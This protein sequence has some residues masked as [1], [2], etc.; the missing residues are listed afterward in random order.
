MMRFAQIIVAVFFLAAV[1]LVV[2]WGA[3]QQRDYVESDEGTDD[4][5]LLSRRHDRERRLSIFKKMGHDI[6]HTVDKGTKDITKGVDD[7]KKGEKA[8]VKGAKQTE[9]GLIKAGDDVSHMTKEAMDAIDHVFSSKSLEKMGQKIS[10]AASHFEQGLEHVAEE[11]AQDV[12]KLGPLIVSAAEATEEVMKAFSQLIDLGACFDFKKIMCKTLL[13]MC[14]CDAG[15]EVSVSLDKPPKIE[16]T[17]VPKYLAKSLNWQSNGQWPGQLEAGEP[18]SDEDDDE[19][20]GE[21]ESD[22]DLKSKM[23][24]VKQD[25]GASLKT[26]VDANIEFIP[27]TVFEL[28]TDGKLTASI[29]GKFSAYLNARAEADA[30]FSYTLVERVPEEPLEYTACADVFCI[31]FLLQAN[32]TLDLETSAQGT[33]QV[34]A[35][36]EYDIEAD[37]SIDVTTG[38]MHA[39][40]KSS[41]FTH[42]EQMTMDGSFDGSLSLSLMPVLTIMPLPGAPISVKPFL[43]GNLSTHVEASATASSAGFLQATSSTTEASFCAAADISI[44]G[45]V[46]IDGLGMPQPLEISSTEIKSMITKAIADVP[47]VLIGAIND[48]LDSCAKLGKAVDKAISKP[49]E[50]AA[51][52]A[53]KGLD[54]VIPDFKVSLPDPMELLDKQFCKTVLQKT[55]PDGESQ[56]ANA[57]LGCHA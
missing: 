55:Y 41:P 9:D 3:D 17:C 50:E 22:A 19:D 12:K 38:Q 57:N 10:D 53:A 43:T 51:Q 6:T 36:A 49:I 28:S 48:Q 21:A 23:T 26:A 35:A 32:A 47:Q 30:H 27:K 37:I 54:E 33:A 8:V 1:I 11:A 34:Q 24:V 40:V 18:S 4:R 44:T 13:P 16:A 29:S 14:D 15:S 52:A 5:L 25:G 56:C 20:D 39:S 42:Q 45:G 31:T 2:F 7:I 46:D